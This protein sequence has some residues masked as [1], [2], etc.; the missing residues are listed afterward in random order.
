MAESKLGKEPGWIQWTAFLAVLVLFTGIYFFLGTRL[1]FQ[2]NQN[3][4]LHGQQK[5]LD[6]VYSADAMENLESGPAIASPSL[7]RS[8]PHHTDGVVDPLWPWL[9]KPYNDEDPQILFLSGKQLNLI[10]SGVTLILIGLAAGR[11]FSFTAGIAITLVAGICN[12]LERSSYF[13]PDVVGSVLMLLTW[14]CALS[15]M[16]RNV[17]WV[18]G[19]LGFLLGL[20]FLYDAL[21]WVIV[22]AFLVVSIG[23]SLSGRS[24]KRREEDSVSQW[25]LS[26]QIVGLAVLIT[27][28]MIVAGPRL[29]YANSRFGNAF[30][31]YSNYT[32]WLSSPE[33]ANEFRQRYPDAESLSAMAPTERPGLIR[34]VKKN[35][36]GALVERVFRGGLVTAKD[37]LFDGMR[38]VLIY[39]GLVFT[40]I[41]VVHR[42]AASRT[43]E[44]VWKIGGTNARW[45]LAFSMAAFILMFLYVSIGYLSHPNDTRLLTLYLPLLVTF[46]WIAH[47][48]RRQ[49]ARTRYATLVNRA[50]FAMLI[51]PVLVVAFGILR[52]L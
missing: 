17:L 41:T 48:F 36:F 15:L 12:L 42:I 43:Y 46:V 18:Y 45:M 16:R 5:F 47:R 52:I 28:F 27:V 33:E 26:N 31:L 32:I 1:I 10:V 7:T 9:L 13:L 38:W 24:I 14:V 19:I 3:P 21:T 40:F 49:L 23:R 11:A 30:H 6:A 50:Y 20:T 2:S 25:N 34:F 29:S 35:G 51:V 4:G 22:L 37:F 44:Q 8:L 39:V